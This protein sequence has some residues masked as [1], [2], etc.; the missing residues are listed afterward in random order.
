MYHDPAL[1]EETLD[2]LSIK[3]SGIYVDVTYGGGGHSKE[4]LE[5]LDD[6][7]K[8]FAFDQD[9]DAKANLIED[10][11]FQFIQQN[12]S[13]TRN[14][15]RMYAALPVDGLLADLGVSFH[16]FDEAK[17]G[18]S[19]RFDGPLDMRMDQSRELTAAKVLNEYEAEDLLRLFRLYGELRNASQVVD[20][21]LAYRSSSLFESTAQLKEV[22]K[23]LVLQKVEHKFL[24]QV[25]QALR[26]EVNQELKVIEDLLNQAKEVIKAGGRLVV[27]TYHSLEDRLVKNY[28]KTGNVEGRLEKD[29]F[30]NIQRPFEPVN[31]K[32]IVASHDEV[33]RNN[34]SRSAKLRIAERSNESV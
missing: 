11:R 33:L 18:F 17:R 25:F 19:F 27:I 34:R 26:I 15:L 10:S 32:P 2:G 12:F 16:Q 21:L 5:R 9:P 30:G 28:M 24:A 4:I 8:L 3:S 31:K 13:F 6:S 20:R 23:G 1:L 7:G 22:L 14:Y 29:F